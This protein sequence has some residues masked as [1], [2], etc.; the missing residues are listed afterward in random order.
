[1]MF[2]KISNFTEIVDKNVRE[3]NRK[4]L[5]KARERENLSHT[6]IK[7]LY[8]YNYAYS[9]KTIKKVRSQNLYYSK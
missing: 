9:N 7:F 2:F 8:N 5:Y 6:S 1:M 3:Q 4:F